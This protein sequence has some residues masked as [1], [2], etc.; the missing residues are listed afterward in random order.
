MAE[1]ARCWRQYIPPCYYD[2]GFLP[3]LPSHLPSA[4][5]IR[6]IVHEFILDLFCDLERGLDTP[7]TFAAGRIPRCYVLHFEIDNSISDVAGIHCTV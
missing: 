3:E 2:R 5:S 1:A 4:C 7:S 6:A